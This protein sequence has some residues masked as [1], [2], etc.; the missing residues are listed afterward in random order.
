M[1]SFSPQRGFTISK[2]H[3]ENRVHARLTSHARH[4]SSRACPSS[5][6]GSTTL[7]S[8]GASSL[9]SSRPRRFPIP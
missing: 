1:S 9:S 6:A 7:A 2:R 5:R 4:P 3:G 8:G